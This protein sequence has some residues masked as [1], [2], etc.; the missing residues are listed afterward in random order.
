MATLCSEPRFEPL[1]KCDTG[2]N[3]LDQD[4]Q[5]LIARSDLSPTEKEQLIAARCGQ[6]KFRIEVLREEQSCRV[7]GIAAPKHLRASHIKPWKD[8]NHSERLD[9]NNGLMLSPHID[10]LFDQGYMTFERDGTMLLAANLPA[11]VKSRWQLEQ[12]ALPRHFSEQ[13]WAYMQYHR[14]KRFLG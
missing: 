10:H 2:T 9:G 6:G 12:A 14:A 7:T 3:V 4:I 13:K 8:S 1:I 5:A 11:E